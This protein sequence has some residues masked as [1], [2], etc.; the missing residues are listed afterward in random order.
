[1]L[2]PK[3][4]S[5]YDI[6]MIEVAISLGRMQT[7]RANPEHYVSVVKNI[8]FGGQFANSEMTKTETEED[9]GI[10]AMARKFAPKRMPNVNMHPGVDPAALLESA[11]QTEEHTQEEPKNA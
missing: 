7:D 2:L 10:A 11:T 5:P 6:A 1:M 8:S 4:F 3:E 9:A